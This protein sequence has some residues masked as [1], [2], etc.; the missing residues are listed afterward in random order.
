MQNRRAYRFI[1]GLWH[2]PSSCMACS[3]PVRPED[4]RRRKSI[5]QYPSIPEAMSEVNGSSKSLDKR[6]VKRPWKQVPEPERFRLSTQIRQHDLDVSAKLPQDLPAGSARWSQH[7]GIGHNYHSF[8][9]PC[10]L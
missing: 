4:G 7:L 2:R 6:T 8:E 1:F 3:R 10:A 9:A 5:R